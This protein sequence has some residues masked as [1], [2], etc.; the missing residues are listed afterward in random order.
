MRRV[1]QCIVN[2]GNLSMQPLRLA[3]VDSS[4]P[5]VESQMSDQWWWHTMCCQPPGSRVSPVS[6]LSLSLQLSPAE[7][8]G[9]G[10]VKARHN[11]PR[12]PPRVTPCCCHPWCWSHLSRSEIKQKYHQMS[13]QRFLALSLEWSN[14]YFTIHKNPR[15][16]FNSTGEPHGRQH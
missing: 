6:S 14:I 11:V 8:I 9:A 4:S 1:W 16:S 5:L 2:K 3:D 15:H 12:P 10:T 13:V 7:L